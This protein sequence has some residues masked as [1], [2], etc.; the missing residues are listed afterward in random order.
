M[1]QSH[2]D[3]RRTIGSYWEASV[4]EP[5]LDRQLIGNAL[6]DVAVVGAGYAGLSAALKLAQAGVSVCVLEVEHVGYGASG[7]NGGFCCLGGTKLNERQLIRAFGLEEARKFVAFQVAGVN[8]VAHR[9]DSWGVDADRHS[10]G[11]VF[12]AHRPKDTAGLQSEGAFLK[13]TFGIKTRYLSKDDLDAE[14]HGGPGFHGGLHVPY[15]FALNPMAYVQALAEQVR[16]AGGKIFGKSP[17]TALSQDGD[18]WRLET[19]YGL[20]RAKKV[21]LAGNGYARE[22]VPK[23]LHGRTL[24][25]MSS[26]QVTRPL[27]EDEL[28]AQGWTSDTMSADTRIL[29]HYFRLLPDRR[30]LFGT[31]GGIFENE[32][33]LAAMRKRARSDFENMFPAWAHVEAEFSWYGHVCLARRLTP[34][35]GEVPGMAGVYAAMGWHGSGI[36]MAS[37]S[38]E[39]IAGLI[40]GKLRREDLPAPLQRPFARFPLPGLR[41]LYLQGAYWWYGIKDR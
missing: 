4:P 23:W 38:G 30:F 28:S 29:L 21:V 33:S 6:F 20:V 14:G 9:L 17:V 25:V 41:K 40:T 12:L 34:F 31:R 22:D 36:A 18:R 32:P 13:E 39:K 8:L 1:L 27:S 19:G 5:R 26:I 3:N 16:T 10:K 37:I 2:T 7:R 24:P 11:E 15:G 35:V